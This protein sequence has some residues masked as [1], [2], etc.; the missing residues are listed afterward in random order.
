MATKPCS[1][2]ILLLVSNS[3]A[4]SSALWK[5]TQGQIFIVT[6]NNSLLSNEQHSDISASVTCHKR[7]S[8]TPLP[9]DL[10]WTWCLRHN[11]QIASLS[12]YIPSSKGLQGS[13]CWH[14]TILPPNGG[15][16]SFLRRKWMLEGISKEH[17]RRKNLEKLEFGLMEWRN[18]RHGHHLCR[19]RS[20]GLWQQWA[21]F[22]ESYGE[23]V[24]GWLGSGGSVEVY[25]VSGK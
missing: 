6:W 8:Q 11:I 18:S 14:T 3:W 9:R 24:L 16:S 1:P 23:K 12:G 15:L 19:L 5:I 13:I 22:A 7:R 2:S 25:Q 20:N 10:W 17:N 21:S 4:S